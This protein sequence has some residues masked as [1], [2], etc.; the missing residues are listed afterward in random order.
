MQCTNPES[1]KNKKTCNLFGNKFLSWLYSLNIEGVYCQVF[2]NSARW[3][4]TSEE[5]ICLPTTKIAILG[6]WFD[7][8]VSNNV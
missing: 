6:G 3:N 7:N 4:V 5:L 1:C 2:G 8:R